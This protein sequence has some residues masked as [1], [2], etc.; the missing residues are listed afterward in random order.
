[1]LPHR[2]SYSY[3]STCNRKKYVFA[4]LFEQF[5]YRNSGE[6]PYVG[7]QYERL[8]VMIGLN[9]EIAE[10]LLTSGHNTNDFR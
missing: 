6:S 1:M 10:R 4:N 9:T 5:K 2:T 8:S 7:K 3:V